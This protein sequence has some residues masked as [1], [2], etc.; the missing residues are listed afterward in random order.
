MSLRR[1]AV[2]LLACFLLVPDARAW[3]PEG[4]RIVA[5]LAQRHL[6]PTAEAQVERLL[7]P[8]H[9]RR[10]ADVANWADD[11]QDD[12]SQQALWK[13]TRGLHYI[14]FR[15]RRCDYQPPRD[16]R[17]D[18]CVVGGLQHYVALLGDRSQS[19]AVRREALKFVVHF[20]GDVHQ[21]LH[22]GYRDDKG[23]NTYQVQF[24]DQGS[25]LHRV[26]DSGMLRT[27]GLD[28]RDYAQQLDARGPVALPP[29]ADK[30]FVAWAEESC[31]LSRDIYPDG[32]TVDA[33]YVRA[34][35]PLAE[36]R[37]RE[38]GRRLAEVLNRTL[39]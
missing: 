30:P 12:P 32:H 28:W 39:G 31:R 33:G 4:H 8:E 17:N 7:A 20:I 27:R 29:A 14:N 21:P 3:G 11:I 2:L 15:D 16:C 22:A 24:Q 26:W 5:D 25:N 38:A 6:S 19:D 10:L 1:F 13:A 36:R 34:Q 37:L 9:T 18:R 23:G 35:L